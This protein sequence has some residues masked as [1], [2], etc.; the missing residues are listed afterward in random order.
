MTKTLSK[1]PSARPSGSP[2]KSNFEKKVAHL[3][4]ILAKYGKSPITFTYENYRPIK[5]DFTSHLKGDA[6][7]NDIVS[8]HFVEV[9]DAVCSGSLIV[10]KDNQ[11]YSYIGSVSIEGGIRQ[12][13][14]KDEQ[15]APAFT[16]SFKEG[17]CDHCKTKRLNRKSYHLFALPD[18][19]VLQIGSTCAKEYFG[20]DSAAFLETYGK[21]FF[22]SYDGTEDDLLSFSRGCLAM[23]FSQIVH[24]LDYATNGFLKWNKKD[25]YYD[26]KAPIWENPTVEAVRSLICAENEGAGPSHL[27]FKANA[28][29][30]NLSLKDCIDFWTSKSLSEN[31]ISTFTFNALQT[32][33][34]GYATNRS[35]GS[36]CYAVFAAFNNKLQNIQAAASPLSYP[37]CHWPK[38]SRTSII[39]S[40][41]NIRK[42]N[43]LNEFKANYY[44]GYYGEQETRFIVDFKDSFGT[45]YHFTTSSVSF[46]NLHNN[47]K[48][49]I[50]ATIGDT[51]PFKGIPYTRLSRPIASPL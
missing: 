34:A 16:T 45:L 13:F 41:I 48:V 50:R 15:F 2:K 18:S 22:V 42:F 19:S 37:P 33:K 49:S 38:G 46:C 44:N 3:N 31:P 24:F 8:S 35:L 14:C 7:K 17:W 30:I 36:F 5:V 23:P 27:A 51:K 20:I 21:T 11:P 47:S 1:T 6:F 9:C 29:E 10:K 40:I 39:G 26:P 12:V 28:H 25:S 4:R 32:L 43:A